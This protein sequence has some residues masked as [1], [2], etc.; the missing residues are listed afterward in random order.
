MKTVKI[1]LGIIV[2]IT[3]IIVLIFA[4]YSG[5]SK[6]SFQVKKEGG[7]KLVYQEVKGSYDQIGSVISKIEFQLKNENVLPIKGF[8]IYL[9]NPRFVEK[10]KLRSEAGCILETADT[11]KTYWLKAKFKIKT[12]PVKN[13]ITAE[14]PYKGKMSIMISVLKVY[15]ALMK[16]V[17]DNGYSENGPIMEIYDLPNNKILYRKE[18]IKIGN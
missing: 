6:V 11:S 4:N 13:Y 17:K 14:F 15:P 18:A 3:V 9:D 16:Y 10:S 2:S 7:E 1:I 8:G 12:F 5:F